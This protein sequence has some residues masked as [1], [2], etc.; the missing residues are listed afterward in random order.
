[1]KLTSL[2]KSRKT[3]AIKYFLKN[4]IFKD[5]TD[6]QRTEMEMIFKELRVNFYK[7]KN[8]NIFQIKIIYDFLL[9]FN[10]LIYFMNSSKPIK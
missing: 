1:M 3:T 6:S 9:I 7:Y 8:K 4:S 2:Y 10:N 5:L